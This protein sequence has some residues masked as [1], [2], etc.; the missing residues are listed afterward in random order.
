M[1]FLQ[2]SE[3][4]GM[5]RAKNYSIGSDQADGSVRASQINERL[6]PGQ[7]DP[8]KMLNPPALQRSQGTV[9]MV[10]GGLF[11]LASLTAFVAMIIGGSG[12]SN[13]VAI[14]FIVIVSALYLTLL[15]SRFV[16]KDQKVRV[17]VMAV[18]M[19]TMA[20]ISL[21]GIWVCALIESAVAAGA[22]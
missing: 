9:W 16:F 22:T 2:A 21:V 8:T 12:A 19:L 4:D 6:A 14:T 10:V 18:C 15:I 13:T 5:A 7:P 3:S 20:F 1:S 11:F 17:R